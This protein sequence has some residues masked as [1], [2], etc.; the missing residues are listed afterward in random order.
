MSKGPS[1]GQEESPHVGVIRSGQ[2]ENDAE[3]DDPN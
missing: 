1:L 2:N 3:L